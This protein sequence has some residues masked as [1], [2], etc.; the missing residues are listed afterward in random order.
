MAAAADE[1]HCGVPLHLRNAPTKMMKAI[2]YGKGY[3][4]NPAAGYRR[5]CP[6]GYLPPELG[7]GRTFF[8]PLDCEPG[9]SLRFCTGARDGGDRT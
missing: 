8:D 6:E 2:G 4:Y 1:A 9:H 3:A 7:A 5:G